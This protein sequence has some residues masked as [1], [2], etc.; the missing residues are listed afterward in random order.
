ME[1]AE[2]PNETRMKGI[3]HAHKLPCFDIL[4]VVPVV[5]I[6]SVMNKTS[7]TT[8]LKVKLS[9]LTVVYYM[10]AWLKKS[11]ELT[12]VSTIHLGSQNEC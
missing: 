2:R 9:H 1:T 10:H 11:I 4:E 3:E 12:N 7:T 5:A 6:F 8:T